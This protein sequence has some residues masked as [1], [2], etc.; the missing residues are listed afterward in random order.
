M[1][2]TKR[3]DFLWITVDFLK[4]QRAP[5][6]MCRRRSAQGGGY[7]S[8]SGQRRRTQSV[9]ALIAAQ[10][11][12]EDQRGVRRNLIDFHLAVGQA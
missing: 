10:F 8:N 2:R 12:V 7:Q 3:G 6:S 11:D 5:A 1:F 9:N 4:K